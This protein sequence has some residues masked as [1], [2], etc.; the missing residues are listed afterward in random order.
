MK[1]KKVFRKYRGFLGGKLRALHRSV[2]RLE[3][4]RE[5]N[6]QIRFPS[7]CVC[8][9]VS[10]MG[11]QVWDPLIQGSI[12]GSNHHHTY[13]YIYKTYLDIGALFDTNTVC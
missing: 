2:P 7:K 6:N 1:K 12:R 5:K 8:V 4:Q 3:P 9:C 11:F 13:I 10:E